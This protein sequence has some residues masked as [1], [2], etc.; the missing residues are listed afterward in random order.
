MDE[1]LTVSDLRLL[2]CLEFKDPHSPGIASVS[3]QART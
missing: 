1:L 3:G 2:S